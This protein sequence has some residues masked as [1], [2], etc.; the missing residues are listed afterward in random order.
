[1]TKFLKA[2]V[3]ELAKLIFIF[4]FSGGLYL[5]IET[6]YRG[7]TFLEM[8]YLAGFLGVIGMLINDFLTYDV[9]YLIQCIIMTVIGTLGEGFVGLYCNQDYHIWDY[10]GLIGTFFDGQCNVF[11]IV[12]WFVLFFTLIPV[13]D[14]IEWDIFNYMP[15]TPPYYIIFGKKYSPFKNHRKNH[16][17]NKK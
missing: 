10:R 4:S 5:T 2:V 17:K 9:D 12:A 6:L 7:Y 11:Y 14:F 8:F 15:D 1:M 3:T 13:M 16:Y